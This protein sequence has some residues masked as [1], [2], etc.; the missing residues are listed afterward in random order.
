VEVQLGTLVKKSEEFLKNIKGV[1]TFS[2]FYK[3]KYI[4][5]QTFTYIYAETQGD[6]GSYTLGE[7]LSVS[8]LTFSM[9]CMLKQEGD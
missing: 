4:C 7:N 8:D 5:T 2:H 9:L 1:F 6:V 3:D